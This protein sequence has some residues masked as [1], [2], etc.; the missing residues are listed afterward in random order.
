LSI[1]SDTAARFNQISEIYDETREPMGAEA[2]DRA[3]AILSGDG[4]ATILEAGVGTGRIAVP[5][6]RRGFRLFGVDLA[7]GMLSKA[8]A[9]GVQDLVL[10]DANH[11]PLRDGEF[12]AALMAHV[13]HLLENP[14]ETFESL[15][16]VATKEIVVFVRKRDRASAREDGRAAFRETFRKAATEL[17]YEPADRPGG[18]W[19]GFAKESDFLASFPPDELVTIED[20]TVVTTIGE[21]ISHFE[22]RGYIHP[23][24]IPE[25]LFRKTMQRV[26]ESVDVSK[27]FT[28][29]RT[30]Q[31]AIWRL[32]G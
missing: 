9:K 25:D 3:A 22:K 30:E 16:R 2:L 23:A 12:D 20:R 10:A 17:G 7:R 32:S 26:A 29:Q 14:G 1:P 24:G 5:L 21:R 27:E 19:S 13:I 31:M 18:W 15:R 6:Q 4:V 8:R 11:L 28:Y